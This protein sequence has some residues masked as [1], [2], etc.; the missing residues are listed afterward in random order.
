MNIQELREAINIKIYNSKDPVLKTFRVLSVIVA[1]L[2]IANM[3]YYHGFKVMAEDRDIFV[4][5][6]KWGFGFYILKYCVRIFYSFKPLKDIRASII[7]AALMVIIILNFLFSNLFGWEMI[8]AIG[9]LFNLKNLEEFFLIV[10]QGY[11]ILIIFSEIGRAGRAIDSF[12]LSPP[13]LLMSSFLV[14][15]AIGCGLLMLPQMTSSGVSMPFMD[16]LFTSISAT[17]VTGLV[18][19]DTAT[20][21]SFKGQLIIMGLIQLGG[22]N[23]ISFAT[24]FAIFVRKGLGLKHQTI[25]QENLNAESLSDSRELF[26]QVFIYSI[27]IEITGAL[28]IYFTWDDTSMFTDNMDR[29]YNSLFHSISAF[30]NAGFSIFTDGLYSTGLRADYSIHLIIATLILLGG[31]GF[32]TLMDV[33]SFKKVKE[34]Q[35]KPWKGISINSRL[36]LY[37]AGI[38]LVS[39]FVIFFV[40]E[41]SNTLKDV[42]LGGQLVGSFFQSVTART[43]G[44]NTVDISALTTPVLIFTIFLMFIG[45]SPGST[46]GGI[47]TNT[48]ALIL[49]GAWSTTR[50]KER[51]ELFK[52]TIP[53]ELLN[54]ALLIFLFSIAYISLMIFCLAIS[55]P[56]ADLI[57]LSFEAV[58]AYCTV[59]LSTGITSE[60]STAGRII[61]MVSMFIGRI[62]TLTVAFALARKKVVNEYKYPKGS[63]MVG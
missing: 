59:G 20:Y 27:L 50:G 44:F 1:F 57:S 47:K 40:F 16:A 53:F 28:L 5:V 10:I 11:F 60:L 37:G 13:A 55:E 8:H 39:G 19:V 12:H 49:L 62:G 45:A 4:M 52:H 29:F 23:I 3:I 32:A 2:V 58:S 38:L 46:G 9:T 48:F 42:S 34:R 26:R 22:L 15:I 41:T 51:L 35:D 17:C 7:E 43:A 31:I 61:I 25:L 33:M 21:F 30:N 63:L 56:E 24:I 36:V 14:L 6:V 54:K 18:V